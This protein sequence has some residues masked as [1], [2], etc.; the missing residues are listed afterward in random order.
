M[1]ENCIRNDVIEGDQARYALKKLKAADSQ[2]ELEQGL[3]DVSIEAQFL[4]CLNHPNV[5]KIRGVAGDPL[6]QNFGL[7]LDRL[8]MTLEDKM[9]YW[10]DERKA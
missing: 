2:K 7:V 9:D 1:S 3:I 4:A 5:T 10:T 8:Y 6:T